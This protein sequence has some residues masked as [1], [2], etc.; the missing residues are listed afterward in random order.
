M[1][2]SP[3]LQRARARIA[4]SARRIDEQKLL[5]ASLR[6]RGEDSRAA[7]KLL[8]QLKHSHRFLVEQLAFEQTKNLGA[9]ERSDD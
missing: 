8:D 2:T 6:A 5:I 4:D 1:K 9:A 3:R 7:A